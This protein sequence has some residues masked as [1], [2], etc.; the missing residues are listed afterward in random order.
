MFA[1]AELT[2]GQVRLPTV[3]KTAIFRRDDEAHAFLVVAGHLEERV[4]A[5]GPE[6]GDRVAV[7]RGARDGERIASAQ[8]D[9]LKNGQRVK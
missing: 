3:P 7:V 2:V 1:D 4:L 8:L 6:L 9:S 5:L